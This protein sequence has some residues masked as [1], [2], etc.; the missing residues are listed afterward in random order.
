MEIYKTIAA[1][2]GI[3][4]TIFVSYKHLQDIFDRKHI[5]NREEYRFAKEFFD[6]LVLEGQTQKHTHP[7]VIEKGYQA[8]TG[9]QFISKEEMD[10]LLTLPN[11]T[12]SITKYTQARHYLQILNN[13]SLIK[14]PTQ[15]LIAPK[16]KYSSA[17]LKKMKYFYLAIYI[18]FAFI[19]LMP[20]AYIKA[21]S[22]EYLTLLPLTLLPGLYIAFFAAKEA[23]TINIALELTERQLNQ[24]LEE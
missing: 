1:I 16:A 17:Y 2:I 10:Y 4:T 22:L 18:L 7:Y 12:F 23:I 24:A 5:K 8:L 20:L 19:A 14:K 11:P 21:D 15:S 6:T 3:A 9:N 13:A